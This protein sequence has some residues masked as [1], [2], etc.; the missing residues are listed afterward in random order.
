LLSSALQTAPVPLEQHA[1]VDVQQALPQQSAPLT[2]V[3]VQGKAMQ[4]PAEQ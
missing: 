4:C 1:S 2:Q 3:A